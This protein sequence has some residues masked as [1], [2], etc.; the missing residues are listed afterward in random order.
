MIKHLIPNGSSKLLFYS[1][2]GVGF[3]VMILV[4]Y[5]TKIRY[6]DL[7]S[8]WIGF[9]PIA[10][11]YQ[12]VL[13]ENFTLNFFS[14]IENFDRSLIMW[15][16]PLVYK[17]LG[18]PPEWMLKVM[19]GLEYVVVSLVVWGLCRTLVPKASAWV[20]FLSLAW[21]LTSWARNMNFAEFAQ[22][23]FVG[24]YY[25]FAD[26]FRVFAILFA[27]QQRWVLSAVFL[28]IGC[29]IH[30]ILGLM[31]AA[32]IAAMLL[33]Q[34]RQLATPPIRNA[35]LVFLGLTGVW[36]LS[37]YQQAGLDGGG[38]PNALWFDLTRLSG[39]HW[40][41]LEA[42]K[43]SSWADL[44]VIPFISFA[45]LLAYAFSQRRPL[46]ETD[47]RVLFGMAGML[48]LCFLGFLFSKARLSPS[49]IKLSLHRANDLIILL[50]IPYVVNQLVIAYQNGSL[51]RKIGAFAILISPFFFRTGFPLFVTI[52]F[53]LSFW[54]KSLFTE[55]KAW[56]SQNNPSGLLQNSFILLAIGIFALLL[57]THYTHA[58]VSTATMGTQTYWQLV[59]AAALLMTLCQTSTLQ[60][61]HA[62]MGLLLFGYTLYGSL[63]WTHQTKPAKAFRT[64]A[65]AYLQT[66]HWAR[67]N[68]PKDALFMVEPTV[69]YGWRDYSRRSSF[70]NL[71]EWVNSSWLYDSRMSVLQEG[72]DRLGTLSINIDDYLKDKPRI[73]SLGRLINDTKEQFY[74]KDDA[75]RLDMA[76]T[77]GIRY[78]VLRKEL[79]QEPSQLPVVYENNIFVVL[80]TQQ[81]G[82]V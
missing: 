58:I 52:A 69:Y 53:T 64:Q 8:A 67:E 73:K 4:A 33:P 62:V 46:A 2:L 54:W 5:L 68:T 19:I 63:L 56:T 12:K 30:P 34:W 59:G 13:P 71:M 31:A 43:V 11:V 27:L 15:I 39:S 55:E 78:F 14:G 9:T 51:L 7:Y 21:V 76:K 26:F 32:F 29:M 18:I 23:F 28:A 36:F 1:L 6:I 74:A 79:L 16:Y 45:L 65:N 48:A 22:P 49:L 81:D 3:L 24:Q 61:R 37:M 38:I 72:L 20:V 42:G 35:L 17:L 25:N 50:G 10:Y 80:S 44:Y 40:Y 60:V 77:H 75:W 41:A 66:Q 47:R 57:G 70:G 82:E